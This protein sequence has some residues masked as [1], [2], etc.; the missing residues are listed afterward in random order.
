M[1]AAE[2]IEHPSSNPLT[3]QENPHTL[4]LAGMVSQKLSLMQS[5]FEAAISNIDQVSQ[6]EAKS[7]MNIL[8]E[9]HLK[10]ND[11]EEIREDGGGRVGEGAG[12]SGTR[13][14]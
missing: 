6:F 11:I 12:E 9:E 13:G 3:I 7:P 5:P 10:E 14:F 4:H 1:V 8:T 2:A